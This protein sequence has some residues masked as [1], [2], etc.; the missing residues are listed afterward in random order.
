M[1]SNAIPRGKASLD[2]LRRVVPVGAIFSI[3]AF[4]VVWWL[5]SGSDVC[6]D[7]PITLYISSQ[8]PTLSDVIARSVTHSPLYFLLIRPISGFGVLALRLVSAGFIAAAI[9]VL[10]HV[11]AKLINRESGG[12]LTAFA[13]AMW[14]STTDFLI[15]GRPYAAETFFGALSCLFLVEV[16]QRRSRARR[17]GLALS[18][19]MMVHFS[20]IAVPTACM[21]IALG[22]VITWRDG[23]R[24]ILEMTIPFLLLVAPLLLRMESLFAYHSDIP[25]AIGHGINPL[26]GNNVLGWMG[27]TPIFAF[28]IALLGAIG[29]IAFWGARH[30]DHSDREPLA[31]LVLMLAQPV[32]LMVISEVLRHAGSPQ[33]WT[34]AN[35][36]YK[37]LSTVF[38]SVAL[39][40]AGVALGVATRFGYAATISIGLAVTFV[41]KTAPGA[42]FPYNS[43]MGVFLT[44]RSAAYDYVARVD[45]S[46][47]PVIVMSDWPLGDSWSNYSDPNTRIEIAAGAIL[48]SPLGA[49]RV[50]PAPGQANGFVDSNGDLWLR[51]ITHRVPCGGRAWLIPRI[52]IE[53][54]KAALTPAYL[55]G[56]PRHSA[57]G[58]YKAMIASNWP[59][60]KL[61]QGG[62][63][64]TSSFETNHP[65]KTV[66][67]LTRYCNTG[68]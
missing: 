63:K 44:E 46:G 7:D 34:L 11:G 31:L 29:I 66:F 18:C 61:S 67:G 58:F 42:A 19:G 27:M 23:R 57:V 54:G 6:M 52:T 14:P 45:P 36:P 49:E 33:Y 5:K 22:L 39:A 68:R 2:A 10:Y 41:F 4:L 25:A 20:F 9:V 30:K 51:N 50:I 16:Y 3:G 56:A 26:A 1:T 64:V 48:A 8:S 32:T 35:L 55:V 47:A 40:Y 53:T 43:L 12:F 37:G 60:A 13:F 15:C 21:L 28:D 17:V 59:I 65:G 24:A 62:F 38:A